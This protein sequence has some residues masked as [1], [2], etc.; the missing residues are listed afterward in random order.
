MR[1]LSLMFKNVG[2]QQIAEELCLSPH[3]V[4]NHIRNACARIGVNKEAE[5]IAYAHRH[6][7]VKEE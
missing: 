4:H 6:N 3:T 1:V 5:L 2:R 7:L